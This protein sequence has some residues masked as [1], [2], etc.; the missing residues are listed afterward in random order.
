MLP[1]H[2]APIA[3]ASQQVTSNLAARLA[4][5][6]LIGCLAAGPLA[7][8]VAGFCDDPVGPTGHLTRV[9]GGGPFRR[10]SARGSSP[11]GW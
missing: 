9:D 8:G 4:S 3:T 11:L 1:R 10:A 5:G 2:S 7:L 6:A